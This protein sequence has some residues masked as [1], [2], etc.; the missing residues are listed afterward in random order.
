[1]PCSCIY[2]IRAIGS[3]VKVGRENLSWTF[4]PEKIAHQSQSFSLQFGQN[5]QRTP[6]L[7][8]RELA[9]QSSS[10]SRGGGGGGLR[11]RTPSALGLKNKIKIL[12]LLPMRNRNN[13]SSQRC[14]AQNEHVKTPLYES[15][16]IEHD[17]MTYPETF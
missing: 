11:V 14:F 5:P 16:I 10:R 15:V 8:F 9:Y 6:C 1:M 7:V 12:I 3:S 13:T 2:Y 4:K 17:R